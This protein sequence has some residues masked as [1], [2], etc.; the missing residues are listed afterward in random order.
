MDAV[1]GATS[2]PLNEYTFES[3]VTLHFTIDKFTKDIITG[4]CADKEFMQGKSYDCAD[5]KA[6]MVYVDIDQVTDKEKRERLK[7]LPTS[8]V[9]QPEQ[10]DELRGAAREVLTN[11]KNLKKF[12]DEL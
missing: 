9:L 3:L 1:L 6:Y 4:R 11:N 10:V 5:F 7:E 8:F 12:M 2:I